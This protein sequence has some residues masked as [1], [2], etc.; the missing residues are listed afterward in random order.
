MGQGKRYQIV[1]VLNNNTLLVNDEQ[2]NETILLGKGI[3]F[4]RKIG[5]QLNEEQWIEKVFTLSTKTNQQAIL[6]VLNEID[7]RTLNAIHDMIRTIEEKSNL[8]FTEPFL[9]SFIDHVSFTMKRLKQGIKISNPFLFEIQT[10]YP[11]DYSLA[12]HGLQI[13]EQS[14]EL[15][16]P[17]DEAGFIALHL[18]SLRT[19]TSISKMNQFSSLINRLIHVIE[20]ELKIEIDRHSIDYARLVSHIRFAIERTEREQNLGENH[21]LSTLLQRE[22]P[23][24]YNI[25]WK[26]VKI[27][28]NSLKAEIPE[29]ESSYLTL[30]I[31][32]ILDHVQG[33]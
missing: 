23:V 3:G 1:K 28:Q 7:D 5:E 19:N 29:A 24:C 26:L 17:Q 9:L 30:H 6:D 10:L 15:E 32:R 21:P 16:I 4:N 33:N 2:G 12:L 8:I 31:R 18:H 20:E 11:D 25:S 27:M 13:L 14:L 22:Y